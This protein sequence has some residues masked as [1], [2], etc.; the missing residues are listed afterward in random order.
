MNNF[1]QHFIPSPLKVLTLNLL[2]VICSFPYRSKFI[3]KFGITEL[4][5]IIDFLCCMFP[6]SVTKL[7]KFLENT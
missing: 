6:L 7:D 4:D 5:Y 2:K 1:P 3:V